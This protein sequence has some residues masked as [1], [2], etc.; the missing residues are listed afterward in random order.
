MLGPRGEGA[1]DFPGQLLL[2]TTSPAPLGA[3]TAGQL[4]VWKSHA[5]CPAVIVTTPPSLSEVACSA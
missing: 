1:S 5:R 3:P 2:L 4:G